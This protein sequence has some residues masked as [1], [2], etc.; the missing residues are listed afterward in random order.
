MDCGIVATVTKKLEGGN[1]HGVRM[2]L[3]CLEILGMSEN[4]LQLHD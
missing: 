1:P 4:R 3:I 2:S